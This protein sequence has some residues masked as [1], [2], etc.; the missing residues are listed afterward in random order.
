MT[1][2]LI[3]DDHQLLAT[4]LVVTLDRVGIPAAA[5]RPRPRPELLRELLDRRP[6]TVLLDLDLGEFGDATPLI[7]PLA[8]AGVRV[9]VMTGLADRVRIAAA[10]EQGALGYRPK[11]DGV[12]AL[13]DTVRRV[14]RS[15]EPLDP[16][17]RATLLE[18]LRRARARRSAALA[19]FERLTE[20]EQET[21]RALGEGRSVREIADAWVVSEATV[22]THVRSLLG[23][24]GAR[25]QLAAVAMALRAGWL[26]LRDS[27][28]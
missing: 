5:V 11:A 14:R 10:L 17:T 15:R 18:E 13:V 2:T 4:A 20:R 3:V 23:K 7:A 24:L 27:A 25:S 9:V 8:D 12:E 1:D 22:R 19:P 16:R 28:L 21:L 6:G 26:E